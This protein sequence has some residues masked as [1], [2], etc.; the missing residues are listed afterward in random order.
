MASQLH[1]PPPPPPASPLLS[2]NWGPGLGEGSALHGVLTGLGAGPA[3]PPPGRSLAPYRPQRQ[4]TSR[5]PGA[6]HAVRSVDRVC[7]EVPQ[8]PSCSVAPGISRPLLKLRSSVSIRRV[9]FSLTSS[10]ARR[11][12]SVTPFAASKE[13][14]AEMFAPMGMSSR[15]QLLIVP[16]VGPQPRPPKEEKTCLR[17][18]EQE[19]SRNCCS[20]RHVAVI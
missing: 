13:G 3:L 14:F 12:A 18:S 9:L 20:F 5:V 15:S 19:D 7:W 10:A 8:R 2:G 4:V 11:R 17:T 1:R 6:A 16:W